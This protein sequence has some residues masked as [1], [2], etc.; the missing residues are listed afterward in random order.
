MS[1]ESFPETLENLLSMLQTKQQNAIQSE[2]IEWLHSFCETFHLKIHCHK[3]F[4][5]S[6]EKN[7]L[8]YP[9][10]KHRETRSPPTMC[11]GLFSPEHS[12]SKHRNLC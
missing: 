2:V 8:K 1:N 7:E 9:L 3:Q 4:I 6:G 11:T 5:P 12:Q 10:K